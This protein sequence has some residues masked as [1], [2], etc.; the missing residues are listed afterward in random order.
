MVSGTN[1]KTINGSSLLGSGDL[2]IS[3]TSGYVSLSAAPYSDVACTTG[4]YGY[5]GSTAYLCT[6][7]FWTSKWTLSAHLNP[8]VS[9]LNVSDDFNRSDGALGSNWGQVGAWSMPTIS[10]NVIRGLS[11]DN[12]MARWAVDNFKADQKATIKLSTAANGGEVCVRM[13]TTQSGYCVK[14]QSSTE[15]RITKFTSG[16]EETLGTVSSSLSTGDTMSISA[17][18]STLTAW[19]NETPLTPTVTDSSYSTGNPG[20]YIW[21][22]VVRLD[23]FYAEEL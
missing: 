7:G 17:V 21:S 14:Y 11:G 16:T 8:S 1:I 5:Y 15:L 10:S 13:Q 3:G 22:D 2:A 4:Q 19:K 9:A 18:G 23:D 12:N 6:G 20:V